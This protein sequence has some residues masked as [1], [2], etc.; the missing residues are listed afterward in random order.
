[1]SRSSS[2]FLHAFVP[3]MRSSV[4]PLE[5]EISCY[6]C[7]STFKI[8]APISAVYCPQCHSAIPLQEE[9]LE[10]FNTQAKELFPQGSTSGVAWNNEKTLLEPKADYGSPLTPHSVSP[11]LKTSSN[12]LEKSET[13]EDSSSKKETLNPEDRTQ[14]IVERPDAL[15]SQSGVPTLISPS[16]SQGSSVSQGSASQSVLHS[17]FSQKKLQKNPQQLS[18]FF[19]SLSPQKYQKIREIAEGG[20]GKIELMKDNDLNRYIARKHILSPIKDYADVLER[21]IG[22]AQTTGQLEHPNIIPIHDLGIDDEG[23]I[24]FTMAFIQGK[25]LQKVLEDLKKETPLA[26]KEHSLTRLLQ[27]FQ[28][29]CHAIHFAHSKGVL[30]RDLKPANIMLGAFGEVVVMDWGLAKVKGSSEKKPLIAPVETIREQL[31]KSTLYGSIV[32]TPSYMPPEQA[33]GELDQMDARSDVYSLGAILYEMLSLHPPYRGSSVEAILHSLIYEPLL[34]PEKLS[35]RYQR[36]V[37]REL[38]AVCVKALSKKQEDRYAT[39][40]ELW[41]DIQ[42][43]L[44]G[45]P[46]LALP[47]TLGKK[48]IRFGK[49]HALTLKWI[50]LSSFLVLFSALTMGKYSQYQTTQNFYQKAALRLRNASYGSAGTFKKSAYLQNPTALQTR[51]RLY[52]EAAQEFLKVLEI[53]PDHSE[54]KKNLRSIYYTLWILA[55]WEN[56]TSL[57]EHYQEQLQ[58]LLGSDYESSIEGQKIKGLQK[59]QITSTPEAVEI[60]IFRYDTFKES[61]RKG[62]PEWGHLLFPFPYASQKGAKNKSALYEQN[63][64]AEWR[65]KTKT[66]PLFE[67]PL[68]PSHFWGK[69]PQTLSELEPGSY[70]FLFKKDGYLPVSYPLLLQH[71]LSKED[72]KALIHSISVTL[73]PENH[74]NQGFT[75][76]PPTRFLYGG[77]S[78]GAGAQEEK[79]AGPFWIKTKEADFG[80]YVEFLQAFCDAGEASSAQQHL[81][82]NFGENRQD[83][84]LVEIRENQIVPNLAS[85]S[86]S[87]PATTL[88]NWKETPVRGVSYLDVQ[89]FLRWKSKKDQRNY[90]LPTEEEWEL[91]ARGADGRKYSWGNEFNLGVAKLSQGYGTISPQENQKALLQG[92]YADISVF[93]VYDLAG[94]VAEWVE[95]IFEIQ[96]DSTGESSEVLRVLRGNAWGLTPVGLECAFRTNGPENYFHLTIGFR[97]GFAP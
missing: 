51:S 87:W 16:A 54:A 2:L 55:L 9:L 29:L 75:Y 40:Q 93:Q 42:W 37:P 80:E 32:G 47:D 72:R 26:S 67:Y 11:S 18:S 77:N 39:V 44:E 24:Y 23:Q 92:A 71:P 62:D 81:P 85:L 1:M 57:K 15:L 46:L 91:A 48:I 36:E 88:E 21:F 52:R 59:I 68:E 56:N 94:G 61:S 17:L 53:A 14:K 84:P 50:A 20:M 34:P 41:Q 63:W 89:A 60:Y 31:G 49:R 35:S 38:S 70:L 13:S 69:T 96:K 97:Y 25:T 73:P 22:E 86:R 10:S 45:K 66:S 58:L 78:A 5:I 76:L 6:H 83:L 27:I 30:H 4:T 33:Q 8:S 79:T 19:S 3:K 28:Q 82:R 95:G 65:K 74:K 64:K 43:Y 12:L 90:R 7:D